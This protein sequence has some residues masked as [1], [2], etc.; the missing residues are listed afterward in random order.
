MRGVSPAQVAVINAAFVPTPAEIEK[1]ER[2]VALFEENSGAGTI[3]LDGTMIDRPH[4][5]Q[6]ER[7]LRLAVNK[8]KA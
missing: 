3:G 6:A 4:L 1:A 5:L 2:I 8:K 7:L